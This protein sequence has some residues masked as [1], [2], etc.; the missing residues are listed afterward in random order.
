MPV[1]L[2]AADQEEGGAA[3]LLLLEDDQDVLLGHQPAHQRVVEHDPQRL[4]PRL[5]QRG[6]QVRRGRQ[7]AL[8]DGHAEG[9]RQEAD[10]AAG[11]RLGQSGRRGRQLGER[12]GSLSMA[13]SASRACRRIDRGARV[14]V[15]HRAQ[16]GE[17]DPAG[18]PAQASSAAPS[19]S[20]A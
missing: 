15:A 4:D 9:A 20:E 3:R 6:A 10:Q 12:P 8:A 16:R 11:A 5:G 7:L 13:S 1:A 2:Q 19:T 18:R 17:R 14:V